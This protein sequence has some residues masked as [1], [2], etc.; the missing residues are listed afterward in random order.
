MY[1]RVKLTVYIRVH[2]FNVL[3]T[4]EDCASMPLIACLLKN[5]FPEII[6]T[7]SKTTEKNVINKNLIFSKVK[8]VQRKAVLKMDLQ[9][10]L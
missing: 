8:G 2:Y 3:C 10:C 1:T 7:L 9:R 5:S 4:F 6:R